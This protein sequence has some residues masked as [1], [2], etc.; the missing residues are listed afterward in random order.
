[1]TKRGL[2]KMNGAPQADQGT[3]GEHPL[4]DAATARNALQRGAESH[5]SLLIA[6]RLSQVLAVVDKTQARQVDM[7]SELLAQR[8]RR[9]GVKP[10]ERRQLIEAAQLRRPT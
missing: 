2:P 10:Q 9:G 1:M 7:S 3:A 8:R 4:Q 6:M 5:S